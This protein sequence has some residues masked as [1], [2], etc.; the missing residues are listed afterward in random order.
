ME[1]T[2]E[3]KLG[4]LL[5][6]LF[7][8]SIFVFVLIVMRTIGNVN[9]ALNRLEEVITKEVVLRHN[10]IIQEQKTALQRDLMSVDRKRRQEA[11]L[12]VPLMERNPD[13][14]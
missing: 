5:A 8:F 2:Q 12:N 14:D 13:D 6:T 3:L 7:L 9:H 10:R 4:L 11:L 1:L